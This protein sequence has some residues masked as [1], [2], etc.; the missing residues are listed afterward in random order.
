MRYH[1]KEIGPSWTKFLKDFKE[2]S[3]KLLEVNDK[4]V[5]QSLASAA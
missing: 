3:G 2:E 4:V 5:L 1:G